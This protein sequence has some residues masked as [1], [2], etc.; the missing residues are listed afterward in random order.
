MK[1]YH[2]FLFPVRYS[3]TAQ[4]LI[5]FSKFQC[6]IISH[7]F[8]GLP[9]RLFPSSFTTQ[10]YTMRVNSRTHVRHHNH[11]I[12]LTTPQKN[13]KTTSKQITTSYNKLRI[14]VAHF[15]WFWRSAYI[16]RAFSNVMA[17]TNMSESVH[18]T[19]LKNKGRGSGI[20]LKATDI[21]NTFF[22]KENNYI[23]K[24]NWRS[25]RAEK[26]WIVCHKIRK[27]Q[28]RR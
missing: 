4:L 18:I 16:S 20:N 23:K 21:D 14:N 19:V 12:L 13:C 7:L 8:L 6:I 27:M 26:K 10:I 28:F 15:C 11:L 9:S 22:Y 17:K 25:L 1:V 24:A 3:S 2:S 5:C